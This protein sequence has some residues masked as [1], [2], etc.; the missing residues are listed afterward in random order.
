MDNLDLTG[1]TG[2][3]EVSLPIL[4]SFFD[5]LMYL[6]Q[7]SIWKPAIFGENQPGDKPE[8]GNSA[9]YDTRVYD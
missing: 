3:F 7:P 4:M 8:D 1:K 5:I 6:A 9:E 2:Q